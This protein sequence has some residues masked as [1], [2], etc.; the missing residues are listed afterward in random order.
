MTEDLKGLVMR[1]MQEGMEYDRDIVAAIEKLIPSGEHDVTGRVAISM[2][3]LKLAMA[4]AITEALYHQI[5]DTC[6][7]LIMIC[8][9]VAP[10][11]HAYYE[12]FST[13]RT[14]DT[15]LQMEDFKN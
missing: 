9:D 3:G 2:E 4:M 6:A 13:L 14:V 1:T 7:S 11:M 10:L 5:V 15:T 8:P 12:Q